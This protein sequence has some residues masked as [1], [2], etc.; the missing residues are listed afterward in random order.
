MTTSAILEAALLVLLVAFCW[1]GV[2]GMWRMRTPTEALH[3]LA[4]PATAGGAL[5]VTVIFLATGN[6]ETAWKTVLIWIVML[7]TNSIVAHATARA[8]RQ[9]QL[10][11][12]EPRDGDPMQ[13]VNPRD[14]A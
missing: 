13:W 3:Y 10:G 5:L 14:K 7:A 4:L 8:F 12:W 11:H 1:L 2:I 9:R 6:S